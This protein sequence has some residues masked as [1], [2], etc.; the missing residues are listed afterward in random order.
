MRRA[1]ARFLVAL[2]A[3]LASWT[4]ASSAVAAAPTDASVYVSDQFKTVA[5][6]VL[7]QVAASTIEQAC[8]REQVVCGRVT[9]R[10]AE[11]F[12]AALSKDNTALTSALDNLF[13]DTSVAAALQ[14]SVGSMLPDKP[15]KNWL[16]GLPPLANCVVGSM[17][18]KARTSSCK[19]SPAEVGWTTA[20][21]NEVYV[22][23][24]KAVA[25]RSD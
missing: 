17:S 19:L 20:L 2:V 15:D 22:D 4:I 10:L 3:L 25:K 11:A 21:L 6:R 8:P 14:L 5:G 1:N 9:K 7:S 12:T 23:W 13:V 18:G 16:Y 24:T